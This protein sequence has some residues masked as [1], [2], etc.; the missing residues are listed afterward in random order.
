MKWVTRERPVIDRI[1]CPW[2]I[3]RFIDKQPE[4]LLPPD[5]VRRVAAETG[6]I[7]Y[8]V[9]GVEFT[10]V[11]EGCSFDAFVATYGLN[12]DPAIVTIAAIVRGADADRHNLTPQSAGLLA[13][14]MGLRDLSPND[15]EVLKRGFIIYDALYAWASGRKTETHS[16]PPNMNP[17]AA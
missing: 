3:S 2:L 1:A 8:D 4:F 5:Q 15:H 9:P 6:A 13:I 7:P 10:H 12:S 17:A 14:S 16:W 11:G